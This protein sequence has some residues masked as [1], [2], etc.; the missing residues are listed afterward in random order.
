MRATPGASDPEIWFH[1][2]RD[3]ALRMDLDYPGYLEALLVTKG[4]IGWQYLYC[5]PEDCGMGFFPLVD[6]LAEMLDVFPRL[7]P[8]HDYADLA[9]R[10]RER[11]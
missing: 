11:T 9:A 5:A 4:V 7:F 1:D 8:H 3:G 2:L 10:L 6:G